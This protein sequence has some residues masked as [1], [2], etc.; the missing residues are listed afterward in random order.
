MISKQVKI[1]D[2]KIKNYLVSSLDNESLL[3]EQEQAKK[4]G[5]KSVPC[6]IFNKQLVISGAQ[7]KDTFVQIIDTLKTNE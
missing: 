6:F 4:I 1:Y 5:I 3:N 2:E 7:S